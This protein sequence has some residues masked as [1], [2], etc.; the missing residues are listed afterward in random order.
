MQWRGQLQPEA[1]AAW[2]LRSHAAESSCFGQFD[3]AWV[4]LISK[5]IVLTGT[6]SWSFFFMAMLDRQTLWL[7]CE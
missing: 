6:S 2:I 5:C 1:S 3:G 7:L 4:N